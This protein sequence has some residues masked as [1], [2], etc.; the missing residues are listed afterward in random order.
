MPKIQATPLPLNHVF[1]HHAPGQTHGPMARIVSARPRRIKP[2]AVAGAFGH[3]FKQVR[4]LFSSAGVR[5]NT[6]HRSHLKHASYAMDDMLRELQL[7]NPSPAALNKSL[8]RVAEAAADMNADLSQL[9]TVRANVRL[10]SLPTEELNEVDTNLA[11]MRQGKE[12]PPA[13]QVLHRLVRKEQARR[14]VLSA[15]EAALARIPQGSEA[16]DFGF[17]G[18]L[19]AADRLMDKLATPSSKENTS[20]TAELKEDGGAD[21]VAL[22]TQLAMELLSR[23]LDKGDISLSDARSLMKALPSDRQHQLLN[24]QEK[25]GFHNA[26]P[27]RSCLA[28]AIAQCQDTLEAAT[29][30]AISGMQTKLNAPDQAEDLATAAIALAQ[31]WQALE[32]HCAAHGIAIPGYLAVPFMGLKTLM[33]AELQK[34]E[35]DLQSLTPEKRLAFASALDTLEITGSYA[36]KVA[37]AADPLGIIKSFPGG[38][39]VFAD[40]ASAQ[41]MTAH[42]GSLLDTAPKPHTPHGQK[43]TGV[44]DAMWKDMPRAT[45]AVEQADGSVVEL[46]SPTRQ[47]AQN[48]PELRDVLG[49]L[50]YELNLSESGLLNHSHLANQ[51]I[52]AGLEALLHTANSPV[53][54]P[55]GTPGFLVGKSSDTYTFRLG[56]DGEVHVRCEHELTDVRAFVDPVSL[57]NTP[58]DESKSHAWFCQEYM[59]AADGKVSVT[60]PLVSS[61][62]L[63]PAK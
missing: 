43:A 4:L 14:E 62:V 37:Y 3:A 2:G 39:T 23:C 41:S 49:S 56:D 26:A 61:Y 29:T 60:Q 25:A 59:V 58:L 33:N 35:P 30:Q 10:E 40:D 8:D 53:R 1:L 63:V 27:M 45:Y 57:Q 42:I 52:W 34:H 54:L 38:K 13:L 51:S 46:V 12:L 6:Q 55:D 17:A 7:D 24:A 9:Y 32:G 20:E 28:G 31:R 18:V 11:L 48:A 44:T 50:R 22:K 19:Q 36:D 16:V 21:P 5:A 15:A 47:L